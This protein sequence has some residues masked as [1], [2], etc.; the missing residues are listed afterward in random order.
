M[1]DQTQQMKLLSM[2]SYT[3]EFFAVEGL[4]LQY[5]ACLCFDSALLGSCRR[6]ALGQV[7]Q[8]LFQEGDVDVA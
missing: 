5:L 1:L 8:S 3:T 7:G 4:A 6:Q 2:S